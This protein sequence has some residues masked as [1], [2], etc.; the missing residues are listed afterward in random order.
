M[1]RLAPPT[2]ELHASF[3]AALEEFRAEGRL[4]PAD[5][6]GLAQESRAGIPGIDD[7]AGFAAYVRALRARARPETPRP[8]GY[9]PDTLLWFAEGAEWIGRLSI[10]H[11]LNEMLLEVGGHIGYDVRPSARRRGHG[12][13]MLRQALPMARQLGIDPAL[14]TCDVD[15]IGSRRVIQANGGLLEDER[16]GKLRF[17]VPS[18]RHA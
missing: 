13:E 2:T 11:R 1:P 3:L 4:G 16:H 15:N 10:R 7:P 14:V 8:L 6:T 9:V 17:W 5:S 12:T 18:G